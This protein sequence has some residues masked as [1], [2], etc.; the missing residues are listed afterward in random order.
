MATTDRAEISTEV[1]AFLADSVVV[2]EGKLYVQGAGWN[3]IWVPTFPA[4]HD[5]IG[6]GIL[7]R[8]P[9]TSTNEVHVLGV[10]LE[11][12]DG[13]AMPVGRGPDDEP[14]FALGGQFSVGRP[15]TMPH[16]DDQIVPV[17]MNLNALVFDHPDRYSFVVSLDD[18]PRA[19]LP[20][21]VM[22]SGGAGG[23]SASPAGPAGPGAPGA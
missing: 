6:V 17:A 11:D 7:V 22:L 2:A 14:V 1:T 9:W 3:I 15:P 21:R 20:F 18:E 5:R 16:G 13:R 10:H 4:Q 23:G 12:G 19:R 8:V